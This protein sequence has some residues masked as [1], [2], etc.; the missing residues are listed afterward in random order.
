MLERDCNWRENIFEVENQLKIAGWVYFV[1]FA[2][3]FSGRFRL[4]C[5]ENHN[6]YLKGGYISTL[7]DKN[8]SKPKGISK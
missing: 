6:K 7:F 2:E 1:V 4:E 5:V 3:T 8:D